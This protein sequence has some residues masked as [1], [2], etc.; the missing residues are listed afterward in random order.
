LSVFGHRF[1]LGLMWRLALVVVTA[2]IFA[3]AALGRPDLGA[4]RVVAAL[5]VVGAATPALAPRPAHPTG[6]WPA[7][8]TP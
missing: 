3:P 4:A 5:F 1:V 8:S 6:S 2:F 7:S